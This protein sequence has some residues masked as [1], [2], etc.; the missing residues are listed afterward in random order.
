MCIWLVFI[1]DDDDYD[2]NNV[3]VCIYV[4]AYDACEFKVTNN[5]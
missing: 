2:Y 1:S 3:D 4:Y 5:K